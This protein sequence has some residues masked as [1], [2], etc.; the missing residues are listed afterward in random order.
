MKYLQHSFVFL[1]SGLLLLCPDVRLLAQAS[2]AESEIIPVFPF[3]ENHKWG[4]KIFFENQLI[5]HELLEPSFDAISDFYLP[6][7]DHY[8]QTPAYSPYRLFEQ[9]EKVGLIDNSTTTILENHFNRILPLSN[10]FFAV[11]LDSL[12][13][14]V[15]KGEDSYSV[16]WPTHRFYNIRKVRE[17]AAMDE[18]HF[19]VRDMDGWGICQE[20]GKLLIQ[21]RFSDLYST[22]VPH[23]Y[24]F[25]E[26][27]NWGVIN[28][29]DS[30]LVAPKYQ[31]IKVL[32]EH[33]F[34]VRNRKWDPYRIIN[35]RRDEVAFQNRVFEKCETELAS[36]DGFLPTIDYLPME[37]YFDS[38]QALNK[39]IIK[40]KIK[41]KFGEG[42][43]L[44]LYDT[45][46]DW[47]IDLPNIYNGFEALDEDHF[48]GVVQAEDKA[49]RTIFSNDLN[50]KI[51]LKRYKDIQATQLANIYKIQK[52]EFWG[53]L[54]LNT[55]DSLLLPCSYQNIGAFKENLSLCWGPDIDPQSNAL[56]RG[57]LY[58]DGNQLSILDCQFD[59]IQ[60]NENQLQAFD[61]QGKRI[62]TYEWLESDSFVLTKSESN[63]N[64]RSLFAQKEPLWQ[65][66]ETRPIK[67]NE[68]RGLSVTVVPASVAKEHLEWRKGGK[69][70]LKSANTIFD[71]LPMLNS[72]EFSDSIIA[73]YL[74]P[75]PYDNAFTSQQIRGKVSRI[76]LHNLR[77]DSTLV[78]ENML[79]FRKFKPKSNQ[80]FTAFISENG[81][82]GLINKKGQEKKNQH[83]EPIRY[84]YIGPFVNG[85][86]RVCKGG[87]LVRKDPFDVEVKAL[88][89]IQIQSFNDFASDFNLLKASGRTP[90][91]LNEFIYVLKKGDIFPK[92]GYINMEGEEVLPPVYDFVSNY[93]K[94]KEI[95]Y[96]TQF[97][98]Y[99][100]SIIQNR[101]DNIFK[102]V[103]DANQKILVAPKYKRIGLFEDFFIVER[104]DT[105]VFFY[106]KKGRLLSI[107]KTAPGPM[108]EGK[109]YFKGE[110]GLFG[111][112][113][114]TGAVVIDSVFRRVGNF[115]GGLVKVIDT[116]G[117]VGFANESG[118]M[119][120]TVPID[121]E[122]FDKKLKDFK[123]GRALFS[124][125]GVKWGYL[126][127]EGQL[128]IDTTYL[129]ISK[130][131]AF[132]LAIVYKPYGRARTRTQGQRGPF[133]KL[134]D[135]GGNTIVE[136]EVYQKIQAFDE[137]G[138]ALVQHMDG[139]WGLYD[140][141][142]KAEITTSR[143]HLIEHFEWQTR[144]SIKHTGYYKVIDKSGKTGVIDRFG[145][146]LISPTYQ[147]IE[148]VSEGMAAV[149][150]EGSKL[151]QLHRLADGKLF[152]IKYQKIA[153]FAKGF[154]LVTTFNED[155]PPLDQIINTEGELVEQEVPIDSILFFTNGLFGVQRGEEQYYSDPFGYNYFINTYPKVAPIFNGL[156]RIQLPNKKW[157]IL[158]DRGLEVV[159]SKYNAL[160]FNNGYLKGNS[161][162][163]IGLLD[164][165][166]N[167]V[168]PP[169]YDRISRCYKGEE[170]YFGFFK[171][172]LGEKVGYFQFENDSFS[173]IH[174]LQN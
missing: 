25:K 37:L 132:G 54:D 39:R 130:P 122:D 17:Q 77:M 88:K 74:K 10:Q 140:A 60:V 166:G 11:E 148:W 18:N 3:R 16:L 61:Y 157:M 112:V 104:E 67:I 79:G 118:Q 89:S 156:A 111:F 29:K 119:A 52:G 66:I 116:L 7:N 114:T 31:E 69:Q 153:P 57:A 8:S 19:Y 22:A 150:P 41:Q 47:I 165:N 113:D 28:S 81:E 32:N 171:V 168:L 35:L 51:Q 34:A 70:F 127:R 43:S 78:W 71:S 121:T 36:N 136:L 40:V 65:E 123:D 58:F 117:R 174:P 154:T 62:F 137:Y 73:L 49:L 38:I 172:E 6:W 56:Q 96:V 87:Q 145:K 143:Y 141:K 64:P 133:P 15:K 97:R 91:A 24:L 131:F 128:A 14:L 107:N 101:Q 120:F 4:Y 30:I 167:V 155:E 92:W 160:K 59:A 90:S 93:I 99:N 159:S 151:W 83:G 94:K 95:A 161:N 164:L 100:D 139:T 142:Q 109:A 173:V 53:L 55:P 125:Q 152:K 63:R 102:G 163:F 134:I 1:L 50:P 82:M 86:A 2:D 105:P 26:K 13:T 169:V 46:I 146:C 85:L 9:N 68:K 20:D 126:D 42:F 158:N 33:T 108:S 144:R 76:L 44:A 21:P 149:K 5:L 135:T 162:Q 84:S 124:L 98:S 23:C 106:D 27:D 12:F 110:N 45:K 75:A 48:I 103:I 80:S 170:N 129:S 147:D 115:S 72:L 138:I